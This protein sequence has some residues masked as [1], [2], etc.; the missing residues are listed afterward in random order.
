MFY[1]SKIKTMK[2][3]KSYTNTLHYVINNIM[4]KNTIWKNCNEIEFL[5]GTRNVYTMFK[6]TQC[7]EMDTSIERK[8]WIKHGL[9]SL[10]GFFDITNYG[11]TI[12]YDIWLCYVN[13]A[14]SRFQILQ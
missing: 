12:V 13:V 9:D 6:L 10:K 5:T 11:S 4:K 7:D 14:E 8:S 2:T 1:S 3:Y